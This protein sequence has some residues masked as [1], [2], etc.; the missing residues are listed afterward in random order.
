MKK[1]FLLLVLISLSALLLGSQGSITLTQSPGYI[2]LL[3]ES[4]EGLSVGYKIDKLI[5]EEI[6]TPEG[7]FTD[8]SV[9]YYATTNLEGLP[10]LPLSRQIIAVPE[11]A[12]VTVSMVSASRETISLATRGVNYPI[13]PRQ[14]PVPKCDNPQDM[15]FLIERDFYNTSQWTSYP[16]IRV[17]ELGHMRGMRL[18]ALDFTPLQYNPALKQVTIIREAEVRVDFIGANHAATQELRDKYYSPAF[19]GVFQNTLLNPVSTRGSLNRYPMGYVIITPANFVDA[20]QPFVDW[21]KKEG[22]NVILATTS[23]TGSTASAIKSYLQNIW[24]SATPENPAPSYLMI[25]GDVAQ[26]PSNTG[27][28]SSAHITDL[29]Y[30]RLQGTDYLPEMYFGRF[31]ATTPAEVTNQVNKTLMHEM[32]T[33]PDDS[34]LAKSVLIAGVDSYW[35]TSHANG[36][37]NY[38]TTNY[39]NPSHGIDSQTFLY[40]ASGS[41]ASQI[42]Q[43]VSEGA[44]YVNYT[45]H[46]SETSWADPSF[47]ISNVNNLQNTNKYPVVVGNCCVTSAFNIGICF[48]EAWLRAVDKGAVVYIGGTNNTYW[49]ED[50]WWAVGYKP[51]IPSSGAGSPFVPGRTGNYD[52]LF[53]E[54]GEPFEDWSNSVAA[55]I[56]MGNMAVVQSNSTRANY[57]W[58]VYSVMGDPSLIPYLG[59]PTDN[60]ADLPDTIFLGMDS[61]E[62]VADPYS[63]VAISMNGVLHGT[64]LASASGEL[65]LYYTPFEEPG[66][67]DIVITRSLV[68]PTI[69]SI[70]VVPNEGPYVTVS[71][72]T[73]TDP[74]GNGM[75]EPGEI[76]SLNLSLNNVGVMDANNLTASIATTSPWVSILE[77]EEQIPNIP[78]DGN[79]TVSNAFSIQISP[80]VPDQASIPFEITITDGEHTWSST[81]S[82]ITF[83][84]DLNIGDVRVTD[85]NDNGFFEPGETVTIQMKLSNDGHL[86]VQGGS[87]Y[88]VSN[89]PGATIATSE[90]DLPSINIGSHIYVTVIAFLDESLETGDVITLGIAINADSQLINH[91]ITIPI[92]FIGDGFE[93]GNFN[94]HPWMNNSPAP[95]TIQSATVHSGSYAA[96]AGAIGNSSS[97]EL[98]ITLENESAGT[99]SFWRKVSSEAGYD[100]LKFLV[101]DNELATWSGNMDWAQ[102]EFPVPPGIVT[103]K[104][105]YQ[106]DYSVSSGSDT[107]WIDDIIF[108]ISS[109]TDAA[110]LYTPITEVNFENVSA[111]NT[112]SHDLIVSNLGNSNMSGMVSIPQEFSVLLSNEQV[113]NDYVYSLEAGENAIFSIVYQAPSPVVNI[114]S[115]ILI[116]SNDAS[117]PAIMLPIRVNVVSNDNTGIPAVTKLEGNFPNPF[118]PTT[119]IRFATHKPGSVRLS[120]FNIKGQLVRKLVDKDLPAGNHAIIWDGKDQYNRSVSS[121]IYLYRMEAPGYTQS[122][123]MMLMK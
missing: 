111:G 95:W 96:K 19:N 66:M 106:K 94:S 69:A 45:A 6:E 8:L 101:N 39:F 57:Y 5:Y 54:N 47:T 25:V 2:Q 107:A 63:Y 24:D 7:R 41:S 10:K 99:I 30:V 65:T 27:V 3:S 17:E 11:A 34:Y 121:G 80:R 36:A 67:A 44:S 14:A 52:A 70:Q 82:I 123:K 120:I 89:H 26:V 79:I 22:F 90:I 68:K 31:S 86:P 84:A 112:Y 32:Y 18:Y 97:T 114:D 4:R 92:G 78:A 105:I 83:A 75:A 56:F 37:I 104:W 9:P 43:R 98:S 122:L 21:K 55:T 115:V 51:P 74:N 13:M 40:P 62:L 108:P 77:G 49:D 23:E 48:A 29:T 12:N 1:Q 58:E 64:G 59:I 110:I 81:R 61:M 116:S 109:N 73:I 76:I 103:F 100:K 20:L 16:E 42:V 60:I 33:M 15:P 119:T 102:E 87:L 117:N 38:A 50:Y 35:S 72:L 85:S 28:T 88:V 91:S 71:P 93:T 113:S 53:H 118:N 46:G